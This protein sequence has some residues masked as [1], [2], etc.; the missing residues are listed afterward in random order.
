MTFSISSRV[1]ISMTPLFVLKLY[2]KKKITRWL[3]DMNFIFRGEENILLIRKIFLPPLKD[4]IHIFAEPYNV[5]Y[6]FLRNI[7]TKSKRKFT[8]RILT[9]PISHNTKKVTFVILTLTFSPL[10][11]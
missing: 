6:I 1:K 9:L 2:N 10:L 8:N 4:K 3:E 11:P 7:S 5:L